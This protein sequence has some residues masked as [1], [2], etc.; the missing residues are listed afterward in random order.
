VIE[1]MLCQSIVKRDIYEIEKFFE[2]CVNPI[3]PLDGA[4]I[5]ILFH[6]PLMTAAIGHKPGDDI[7]GVAAP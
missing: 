6:L 2:I 5:Y 3:L 1:L 7:R 4:H